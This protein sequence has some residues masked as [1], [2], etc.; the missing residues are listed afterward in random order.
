MSNH[1][2][3]SHSLL[4]TANNNCYTHVHIAEMKVTQLKHKK[5]GTVLGSWVSKM[6]VMIIGIM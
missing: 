1:G 5:S 3:Q 2:P 6:T 4:G